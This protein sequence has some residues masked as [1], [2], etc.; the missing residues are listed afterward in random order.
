MTFIRQIRIMGPVIETFCGASVEEFGA[1]LN[2]AALRPVRVPEPNAMVRDVI[3]HSPGDPEPDPDQF[4]LCADPD[5]G[6]PSCVAI[7]VRESQAAKTLVNARQ[8]QAVF[9]APD[10]ARWSDIYDRIK[11]ALRDSFGRLAGHDAFQIAD[12]LA[13]ALGG[14]V[15]IED[16]G[17]RVIAFSTI[18]GQ[19]LDDVRRQGILDRAVPDHAEREDWYATL[20]RS[21]GVTEFPGGRESTAR[22]A[23]A[24]RSGGE[25]LGSIW[26]MGTRDTLNPDADEILLRSADVVAACLAH[27]DHFASRDRETRGHLLRQLLDR[28]GSAGRALGYAL[29]GPTVL[30]AFS[31]GEQAGDRE[32]LDARLSDVLSLQAQRFQGY[33]LAAAIDGRVYALLPDA[34]RVRLDAQLRAVVSRLAPPGDQA[35]RG[36]VA[37]SDPV[38]RVEDLARTRLRLDRLLAL[39]VRAEGSGQG[40]IAH[41][42]DERD[43]LLLAEVADATRDIEALQ[44][45]IAMRIAEYDGEH[46]TAY[47]PTLRAWFDAGGDVAAAAARLHVHPNTFRYRIARASSLFGLHLDQPDERLLLHL[48]MRLADFG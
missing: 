25:P 8:D 9:V 35:A 45:G 4:A 18:P 30:V 7:A 6:L 34:G 13:A 43:A 44:S 11:L 17:R 42:D 41:V 48:Q 5:A 39:R 33:G 31:R 27:Q 20:W 40:D 3:V 16:V 24:V 37:V 12:A 21:A 46:D 23:I 38:D 1:V 15:S 19:P 26:V 2:T 36:T 14:A 28:P 32:L 29:P 10:D 22:L 47:L